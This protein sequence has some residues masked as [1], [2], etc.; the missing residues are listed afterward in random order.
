MGFPGDSV[1]KNPP[2]NAGDAGLIPEGQEDP[3]EKEMATYSSMLAWEISWTGEAWQ[4]TVHVVTKESDMTSEKTTFMFSSLLAKFP[5]SELLV[6]V[7]LLRPALARG[8]PG[9][10]PR[11]PDPHRSPSEGWLPGACA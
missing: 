6:V 4:A 11:G 8:C 1:V 2:V 9:P 3:Q 5:K 7:S 10:I